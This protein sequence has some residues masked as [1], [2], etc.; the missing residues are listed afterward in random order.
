MWSSRVRPVLHR[1]PVRGLIGAAALCCMVV[2]ATTSAQAQVP[3]PPGPIVAP[4]SG[5]PADYDGPLPP[6][7]AGVPNVFQRSG[8]LTRFVRIEPHL[9]PDRDRDNY[10]NTR[11]A[12][13]P[14][15]KHVNCMAH[16]GIYGLP[17]KPD[18]TAS[19]YP[20]FHGSPGLPSTRQACRPSSPVFR[21][22]ENLAHPFKPVGS[23]YAGG[24]YVPLYDLDPL[25]TGPGPYPYPW[26]FKRPTGG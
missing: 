5:P 26:F 25:V 12:N 9:P 19:V 4:V 13:F 22:V 15:V 11:W 23:Y 2:G 7:S 17:W 10:Y 8:L 14:D 6:P 21:L 20:Y 24:S 1:T 16:S 3:V 18:C